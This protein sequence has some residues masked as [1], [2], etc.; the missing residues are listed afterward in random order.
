M[1]CLV[2]IPGRPA[3]KKKGRGVDL[4]GREVGTGRNGRRRNCGWHVL[5]S[6]KHPKKIIK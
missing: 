2:H 3:L 1:T 5:K 4:R 6:S